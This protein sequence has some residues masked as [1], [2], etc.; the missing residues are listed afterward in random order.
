MPRITIPDLGGSLNQGRPVTELAL[1]E[2]TDLRNFYQFG[3]R[4][5]RR[6]GMRRVTSAAYAER[7]TGLVSYRPP[8]LPLGGIDMVVGTP[9]TLGILSGSTITA[10]PFLTGFNIPASTRR[11][12]LFQY[13]NILYGVREGANLVRSDAT[14]VGPAGLAAP[15]TAP[16]LADGAAG[17][18][19]AA[20]FKGVYTF[21]NS[22]TGLESNPS[23]V[24]N[25]L[26]HAGSKKIDWSGIGISS[27][28]Q[29]NARRLYRSLPDQSGE[30]FRVATIPNNADTTYIGDNVLAQDLGDAVSYRNGEPP[31]LLRI[32][33]VWNERLFVSDGVDLFHSELGLIEAFDADSVI[34]VFPDDRHEIRAVR[35]YGDRLII[36]KTN[37][38]HYL[39]GAFPF[40]LFTLSDRHGC[41]S[42]HSMQVAEGHLF[43]L[44][45]DNVYRSDG[46][47]VTGIASV[48]LRNI[49]EALKLDENAEDARDAVATVYPAQ[50]WY[51][52]SI[53]GYAQVVYNYRTDVWSQVMTPSYM[54]AFGDFFSTDA[55]QN[56]YTADDAGHVYHFHDFEPENGG[57]G[58]DDSA[59]VLG[60][61]IV[62]HFRSRGF[63][64][65]GGKHIIERVSLLTPAQ[66]AE[67]ITLK[68]IDALLPAP[69]T[70]VK[71][72]TVSLDYPH[73][74]KV[75][76]LSTRHQPVSV[77][78][79]V[80]EYTGE[81]PI[82]ID[83]FSLEIT[84]LKRPTMM[85]R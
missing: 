46:T 21:Y 69:P 61:P 51:V 26:V 84:P 22:N 58:F 23:P 28:G 48:K 40:G 71:S 73:S 6:G 39:T 38:I 5:R 37:K 24:S 81:T 32:G 19:P 59:S 34:P 43:W 82:E 55:A 44:G 85:A 7:V 20:N 62:A 50:G 30:Y 65:P 9:T 17:D 77:S 68:I 29:A 18:I 16:T 47:N 54:E 1:N 70:E 41:V 25:V 52:L 72:R 45:A 3:G 78:Q 57:Y 42:H 33:D 67:N 64:D 49:I 8:V 66:Y 36:G 63:T 53:P 13:K 10:I 31:S 27:N 74:W 83:G 4:L 15:A 35:A 80:V 75:Y 2:F 11:W 56:I 79:L 14:Y 12:T 60:A 76:S